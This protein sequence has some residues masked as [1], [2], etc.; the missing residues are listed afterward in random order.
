[1]PDK[2]AQISKICLKKTIS[3]NFIAKNMQTLSKN[4][5]QRLR[6]ILLNNFRQ[7]KISLEKTLQRNTVPP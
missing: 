7:R 2:A 6:Q 1:M 3:H 5:T 4:F